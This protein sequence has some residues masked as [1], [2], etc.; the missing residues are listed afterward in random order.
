MKGVFIPDNVANLRN[1]VG[2]F[3]WTFDALDFH[4]VT[5]TYHELATT[6]EKSTT[7]I[8]VGITLVLALR[9]VGAAIFGTLA[10]LLGRKWPLIGNLTLLIILEL[11]T[12]FCQT[13]EQFLAVRALFGIAM[14]GIY[15]NAAATALEDC[16]EE[17]RGLL[18]GI[19]QSG[20]TFGYLLAVVFW[21]S[22]KG[23]KSGWRA[24]FWLSSALPVVLIFVRYCLPETKAY[25]TRLQ[26]RSEMAGLRGVISEATVAVKRYLLRLIYLVL[27]MAGFSFMVSL[28]SLQ[29]VT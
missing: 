18:S 2:F 29:T 12:G 20:Y 6:F 5:Q 25:R 24:L 15:G 7:D 13:Y 17:A 1:K 27:L 3:A 10:D 26:H 4:T 16:D 23:T 28:F 21:Q 9:P 8:S 11:A 14:G 19:Y 22:F